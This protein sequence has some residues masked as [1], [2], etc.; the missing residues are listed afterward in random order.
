MVHGNTSIHGE[1]SFRAGGCNGQPPGDDELV[2]EWRGEARRFLL[3]I[4]KRSFVSPG[5]V[6]AQ[7][8]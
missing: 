8:A 3:R 1:Y 6:E 7:W 5:M 4:N 2:P